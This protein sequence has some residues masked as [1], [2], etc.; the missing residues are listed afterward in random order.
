MPRSIVAVVVGL[1]TTLLLVVLGMWAAGAATGVRPGTVPTTAY[2]ALDLAA[3]A[4][5]ALVGGWVVARIATQAPLAH[6]GVLAALLLLLV[7]AGGRA[8]GHPAWFPWALALAGPGG[9]LL[10]G[11]IGSR[12]RPHHPTKWSPW[13]P[14]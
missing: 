1:L 9:A 10:G 4:I 2:L 13:S 5:G 7:L 14:A 8:A 11:A 6:A 3:S 12:T